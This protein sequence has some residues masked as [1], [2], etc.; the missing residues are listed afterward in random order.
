MMKHFRTFAVAAWLPATLFL[1][2]NLTALAK[3]NQV[4]QKRCG[5]PAPVNTMERPVRVP[6]DE[7]YSSTDV[8]RAI[9][10]GPG[11][12]ATST[13]T[14][15]DN[16]TITD[17][18]VMVSI[19]HTWIR[20]LRISLIGPNATEVVLLNL[21]EQDDAVNMIQTWFDDEA[22]I[23]M[24]LGTPPFTGSFVPQEP[25][26]VFDNISAQGTWT[27]RVEDQ[28]AVDTGTIDAWAIEVNPVINMR[29]L[30][31]DSLTHLGLPNVL[32]ALSVTDTVDTVVTTHTYSG[33]TNTS[34]HY[35]LIHVPTDTYTALFTKPSYDTVRV[36]G[37][38]ITE[39][40]TT[41]LNVTLYSSSGVYEY[42]STS[43]PVLIPDGGQ[44]QMTLD[45]PTNV[46][47]LDLD[48][49]VN[50]THT[51]LG[52]ISVFL[53]SPAPDLDTVLLFDIAGDVG[54]EN[55]TNTR[56][57][58]EAAQTLSQGTAPYTGSFR[59][60]DSLRQ[61]DGIPSNG[62]WTLFVVDS[63]LIDSGYIQNFTLYIT[64]TLDA[65]DPVIPHPS[66]FILSAYPNP[67]NSTT[68]FS[69]ELNRPA[70]V[71]L[72]VFDILGR[73][74]A[75][76][77]NENRPAGS[78]LVAFNADALPSGIYIARLSA[79]GQTR[80]HKVVLLK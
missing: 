62:T 60:V 71:E 51:W 9:P 42:T 67:F 36:E 55:L 58:D 66:S 69:F 3:T 31:T 16:V 5:H 8:P 23:P 54:G 22:A 25:L 38:E 6:L 77:L 35:E 29:G 46:T 28:F 1:L 2:W 74:V 57:D 70:H 47:I 65:K 30:V 73:H 21:L 59:P 56:F 64:G 50:I 80:L 10:D 20:D 13:L 40:D 61:Y 52:D 33:S 76:L 17:L 68:Q 18:N 43:E 41:E 63:A 78:Q 14:I 19:T 15:N 79:L 53:I 24:D 44:A 11:G 48:V 49:Q 39:A 45:V 72:T 26:S 7:I 32:V 34:G 4:P 75:T 27:L 12:V 37:V